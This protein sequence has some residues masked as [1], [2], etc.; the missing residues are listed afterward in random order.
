RLERVPITPTF[1][2]NQTDPTS[3]AVEI[4]SAHKNNDRLSVPSGALIP[5]LGI[6]IRASLLSSERRLCSALAMDRD[7]L[8]L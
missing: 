5:P 6:Y 4:S 3:S 2:K 1:R 8:P 7:Q